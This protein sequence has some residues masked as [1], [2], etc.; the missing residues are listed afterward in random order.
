LGKICARYFGQKLMTG[1]YA[2]AKTPLG[3]SDDHSTHKSLCVSSAT[4][5][6]IAA[7][8]FAD[9]AAFAAGLRSSAAPV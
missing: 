5:A 8:T 7:A 4:A 1:A 9:Q 3:E 6:W 2:A